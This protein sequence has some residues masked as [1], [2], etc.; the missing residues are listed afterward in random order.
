MCK[1]HAGISTQLNILQTI[2]ANF[3]QRFEKHRSEENLS[4]SK[5]S[6]K[7]LEWF[8]QYLISTTLVHTNIMNDALY[9]ITSSEVST[10][11][12]RHRLHEDHI[13]K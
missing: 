13:R 9:D 4:H 5:C 2:V 1:L 8:D 6:R 11:I 10:S 3:L 7:N 12:I